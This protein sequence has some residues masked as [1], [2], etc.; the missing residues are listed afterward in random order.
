MRAWVFS[1]PIGGQTFQ[2]DTVF[3]GVLIIAFSGMLLTFLT[4][5][6][7]TQILALASGA[8]ASISFTTLYSVFRD[9]CLNSP[10]RTAMNPNEI[11]DRRQFLKWI[12]IGGAA[13]TFFSVR[14]AFARN[15]CAHLRR[16]K[17][18]IIRSNSP[19]TE[20]TTC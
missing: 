11:P 5:T 20:I 9:P 12:V 14:G 13:G 16:P 7:R 4:G 17:V 10:W 19:W 6:P 8:I 2:T 3:V 15:W 18:R 1:W